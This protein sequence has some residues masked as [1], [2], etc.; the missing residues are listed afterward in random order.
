MRTL[1]AWPSNQVAPSTL[2]FAPNGFRPSCFVPVQ[3]YARRPKRSLSP[4]SAS[5]IICASKP[6]P[7]I[8]AKRSSFMRPTSSVRRAPSSPMR[9][10]SSMSCGISRFEA[11]RLAVPAGTIA[12]V[13][14]GSG[15]RVDAALH[16]SVAAP[17]EEQVGAFG[18]GA[19]DLLRGLAALRHLVPERI[20]HALLLEL[21]PKLDQPAAEGLARV[22][23]D[24]DGAHLV[25]L[26]LLSFARASDHP[27]NAGDEDDQR[28]RGDA[29]QNTRERVERMVHPAIHPRD[30][31]DERNGDGDAPDD[32]SLDAG[33]QR[34]R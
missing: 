23:D 6:A 29:D 8:T 7:A 21:A 9:T 30:A 12:I 16:H 20:R 14:C 31:D 34:A 32:G 17:D 5:L 4:P 18:E 15:E 28:E 22:G 1:L 11:K 10:A 24:G 33:G 27:R 13:A 25:A 19:L 2:I 3:T 26:P